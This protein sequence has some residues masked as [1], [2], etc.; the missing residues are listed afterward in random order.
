MEFLIDKA[1]GLASDSIVWECMAMMHALDIANE[2][3]VRDIAQNVRISTL[4]DY[5]HWMR[6]ATPDRM[7]V[8]KHSRNLLDCPQVLVECCSL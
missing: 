2:L 3:D 6:I 4:Q 5:S 8:W 1:N 7:P